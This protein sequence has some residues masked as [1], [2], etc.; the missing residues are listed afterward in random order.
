MYDPKL[1]KD[2]Q[3]SMETTGNKEYDLNSVPIVAVT[4]VSKKTPTSIEVEENGQTVYYQPIGILPSTTN[5]YAQGANRTKYLR[6]QLP[7]KFSELTTPT[8]LV[9]EK[10]D[11]IATT[12]SSKIHTKSPEKT[13]D[14]NIAD[15]IV[16][17]LNNT[18][19]NEE[20]KSL[21]KKDRLKS[22]LY[23]GIRD[24][25]IKRFVTVKPHD[26]S[27]RL[28][29]TQ[30][31]LNFGDDNDVKY[32]YVIVN[33]GGDITKIEERNS[34]TKL[35]DLFLQENVDKKEAINSNSRVEKFA[36]KLKQFIQKDF[37]KHTISVTVNSETGEVSATDSSA[38]IKKLE[39]R[40]TNSLNHVI[41]AKGS[42]TY[43]ITPTDQVDTNNNRLFNLSLTNQ[44]GQ[45]ISIP[46][47]Q[48]SK[49]ELSIDSQFEI[50]QNLKLLN[51]LS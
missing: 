12:F 2:V 17:Q 37:S 5:P 10:G 11:A 47:G 20:L 36:F 1:A 16:G 18:S 23:K 24:A 30:S 9:D 25:F 49:S 42:W 7:V 50:L 8:L 22:P 34:D 33:N 40:L 14:R 48:I 32:Q 4:Q 51:Q 29:F 46:L 6:E 44:E 45:D 27:T 28:A 26:S 38:E 21:N 35:V 39:E 3:F 15:V 43:T 19:E 31:N 41:F 13:N